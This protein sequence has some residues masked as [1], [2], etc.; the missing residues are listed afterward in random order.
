MAL[1]PLPPA[2]PHAVSAI[3]KSADNANFCVCDRDLHNTRCA[4]MEAR[5][6]SI[7]FMALPLLVDGD[8]G[9]SGGGYSSPS[10]LRYIGNEGQKV[11][12]VRTAQARRVSQRH[13]C[14]L[15][16][17]HFNSSIARFLRTQKMRLSRVAVKF[18][19]RLSADDQWM[20]N[21]VCSRVF[22]E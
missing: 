13:R 21:T 1:P 20:G 7:L 2:P 12:A 15:P 8:A 9:Q 3:S 11:T 14:P 5:Q 22:L 16:G 19:L 17:R 6:S 10:S 4:I 18:C